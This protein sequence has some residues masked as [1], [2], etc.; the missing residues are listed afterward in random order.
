[1]DV[2]P[3]RLPPDIGEPRRRRVKELVEVPL[4]LGLVQVVPEL[5][6]DDD[7]QS[8]RLVAY[9]P[10]RTSIPRVIGVRAEV[11]LLL[12]RKRDAEEQAVRKLRED[13]PEVKVDDV[14][15]YAVEVADNHEGDDGPFIARSQTRK[16]YVVS[17]R[18]Y[19]DYVREKRKKLLADIKTMHDQ[20]QEAS[21][22]VDD[23]K[24]DSPGGTSPP[25][26]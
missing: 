26:E 8:I 6:F 10:V 24:K 19:L 3:R 15:T 13:I 18:D 1:M 23:L 5:R 14:V 22:Q 11:H 12:A 9:Q 17:V 21:D 16:I 2:V 4:D 25:R 7:G 20:E